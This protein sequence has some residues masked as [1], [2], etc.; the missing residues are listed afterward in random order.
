MSWGFWNERLLNCCQLV[1]LHVFVFLV[2]Q[3]WELVTEFLNEEN[4]HCSLFWFCS[5]SSK[6]L[7]AI[8]VNDLNTFDTHA[9]HTSSVHD[10]S[11]QKLLLVLASPGYTCRSPG[12]CQHLQPGPTTLASSIPEGRPH[13]TDQQQQM[14]V[15]PTS[16]K[17]SQGGTSGNRC[18]DEFS[19]WS[20]VCRSVE[21][22]RDLNSRITTEVLGEHTRTELP[23]FG[24]VLQLLEGQESLLV[25]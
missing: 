19:S 25:Y 20:V 6:L 4:K 7:H 1:A 13:I 8:S 14:Q 11:S 5:P 16:C 17:H 12:F 24:T 10:T 3:K 22:S 18:R 9:K 23:T 15:V 2:E 21:S